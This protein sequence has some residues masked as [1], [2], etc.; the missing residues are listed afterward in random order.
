MRAKKAK[1]TA[2]VDPFANPNKTSNSLGKPKPQSNRPKLYSEGLAEE[3]KQMGLPENVLHPLDTKNVFNT[4]AIAINK[5]QGKFF[6]PNVPLAK[7]K[8]RDGD[9]IQIRTDFVEED[10]QELVASIKA[11][12]LQVPG[13]LTYDKVNDVYWI[14]TGER[15]TRACIQAGLIEYPAIV[16]MNRPEKPV[17]RQLMENVHRSDLNAFEIM[18][19]LVRIKR[20]MEADKPRVTQDDLAH[21]IK[22]SRVFVAKHLSLSNIDMRLRTIIRTEGLDGDFQFIDAL[23]KLWEQSNEIV[24]YIN[25]H[26]DKFTFNRALTTSLLKALKSK[27]SEAIS[28]GVYNFSF[29][30]S[31]Q[32]TSALAF[33]DDPR[34]DAESIVNQGYDVATK[35][36]NFIEYEM[37]K[38][39]SK[40]E[41]TR[42][43]EQNHN[44]SEIELDVPR[45]DVVEAKM[46]QVA[47]GGGEALP[48]PPIGHSTATDQSISQSVKDQIP[49]E[50]EIEW[51]PIILTG[52]L[53][54]I[55]GR[56]QGVGD[57]YLST[58]HK[59]EDSAYGW[60]IMQN[61]KELVRGKLS[62]FS[63]KSAF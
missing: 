26:T 6:L 11:N 60:F 13:E 24:Q 16:Y 33:F 15:R 3:E 7:V 2:K 43:V 61:G 34:A 58:N 40:V 20:E 38:I 39:E 30:N 53:L 59:D 55:S 17:L 31:D 45:Y 42:I 49:N 27:H 57:C 28:K 21:E 10:M 36:P 62:S 19:A 22:K 4:V 35:R 5:E 56:L 14:E 51:H 48:V 50:K 54:T 44:V 9:D 41:T 18:E 8:A 25:K 37:F 47:G 23:R 52:E 46:P 32:I 29:L 12:G 1:T 63:I